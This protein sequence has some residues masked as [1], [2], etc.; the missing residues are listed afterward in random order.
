MSKPQHFKLDREVNA[1]ETTLY[2]LGGNVVDRKVY[3][4]K[5]KALSQ[6]VVVL[7]GRLADLGGGVIQIAVV[8]VPL[9]QWNDKSQYEK[10][11]HEQL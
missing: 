11:T 7:A 5:S 4:T 3:D 8:K 1:F 9:A 6:T 10:V 2:D